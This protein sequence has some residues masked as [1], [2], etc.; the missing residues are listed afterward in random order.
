MSAICPG[1]FGF[2]TADSAGFCSFCSLTIGVS[3][4]VFRCIVGAI[5]G[6][7]LKLTGLLTDQPRLKPLRRLFHLGGKIVEGLLLT[8][9]FLPSTASRPAF[10]PRSSI[11][12]RFVHVKA[13]LRGL[14]NCS[15]P[16]GVR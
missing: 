10:N 15:E 2:A 11:G 12:R 13:L 1:T 4:K 9:A 6:D 14:R 7:V 16:G 3:P 8:P 5:R